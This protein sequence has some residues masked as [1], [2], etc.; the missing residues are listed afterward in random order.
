VASAV[1][2]DT[3]LDRLSKG[4]L[5]ATSRGD[6]IK[7]SRVVVDG[8]C[9]LVRGGVLSTNVLV[10]TVG[11]TVKPLIP[12]VESAMTNAPIVIA[13]AIVVVVGPILSAT[14]LILTISLDGVIDSVDTPYCCNNDA[15]SKKH[16]HQVLLKLLHTLPGG[17]KQSEPELYTSEHY[18]PRATGYRLPA[19]GSRVES[20]ARYVS[21]LLFLYD[22]D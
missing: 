15:K 17:S 20:L 14:I 13:M 21:F 12:L 9:R 7:P 4:I 11:A 10:L 16:K 1:E 3:A 5:D 6:N 22:F 18:S 8:I 19:T 2:A